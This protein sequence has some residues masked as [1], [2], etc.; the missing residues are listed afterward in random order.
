MKSSFNSV[1]GSRF[2]PLSQSSREETFRDGGSAGSFPEQRLVLEP[3]TLKV[4]AELTTS[5]DVSLYFW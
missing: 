5:M 1:T 2:S 3:T 4:K